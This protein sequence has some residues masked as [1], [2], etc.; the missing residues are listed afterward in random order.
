MADFDLKEAYGKMKHKLPDFELLISEFEVSFIDYKLKDDRLL[1]TS[2]RRKINEKVIFY[3]RIIEGLLYPHQPNIIT[4]MELNSFNEE[5]KKKV[6]ELYKKMMYYER[7]SLKLDVMF[8]EKKNVEFINLVFGLWKEYGREMKWIVER[9]QK[10]W[11][12]GEKKEGELL[13]I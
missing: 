8:D 9:M 13:Q 3:C 10:S 1:L 7:E 2:I 11:A 5:E 12:E 6:H 4:M